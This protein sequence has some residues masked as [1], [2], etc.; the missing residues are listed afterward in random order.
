[1]AKKPTYKELEAGI[2]SIEKEALERMWVEKSLNSNSEQRDVSEMELENSHLVDGKY[3]IMD[4]VNIEI[5]HNALEKFSSASGFTAGL[6]E[7]PSQKILIATGWRN[8]CIKFHRSCPESAE[9]CRYSNIHLTKHLNK[10]KKLSIKTCRNGLVYG[11]TPIVVRGKIIAHLITEQI[12]FEK[13]DIKRFKKQAEMF[14]YDLKSYLEALGEVPVVSESQFKNA[15]SFLSE[16]AMMI[17]DIGLKNLEL[18]ERTMEFEKEIE[19][20][21]IM[22]NILQESES[23]LKSILHA[24]PIG[25]GVACD[26]VIKETNQ[27]LCEMLGYSS[28]EILGASAR[29]FYPTNEDFEFVGRE[30]YKQIYEQGIGFVET[31]MQRKDGNIIDVFLS[32]APLNP[33]DL[34]CGITFSVLDITPRKQSERELQESEQKYRLLVESTPDWVWICDK[35]GRHTFSNG[36]VKKILG[37]E[38][39]EIMGASAFQFMHPEDRK[40]VKKWFKRANKKKIGWRGTVIRWQHKDNSIRYL[41]T[42]AEPILDKRGNLRGFTGIDRDVTA[43]I[44]SKDALQKAHDELKERTKAL[45]IKRISLEELNT[46]MRILLKKR[47]ADKAKIG[48]N[49]LAN[50]KKLIEPYFEKIKNTRLN[51]QQK[52]ILR[53]LESNLNEIISPFTQEVSLKYFKLTSTEI[54]VAKQ[55][56]HGYTTKEIAS[57]MNVSPRTV[58]THRKNIRRKIGLEG[59]K[60]NLRSHLLS[61][62]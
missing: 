3:S 29:K 48:D 19:Q 60:A 45:E 16:L 22:E 23:H 47:E 18:K 21:K 28:E 50:V 4:L 51:N 25:I 33:E 38:V 27:Q 15:L 6:L 37:Y 41:E 46:A 30:K 58:E 20:R 31:C 49:V 54:L 11:V 52:G 40:N 14:G 43:H 62:N 1:M 42:I 44:Q 2:E 26:R 13:P 34:S 10:L 7:Y 57:F 17:A 56:R 36:G 12:F 55:I 39:Q 61:I 8:I 35:E 9:N 32:S 53:I 5:L 24:V 59:K